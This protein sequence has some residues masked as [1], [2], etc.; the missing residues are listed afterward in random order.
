MEYCFVVGLPY[1][2]QEP[3]RSTRV[4]A[5]GPSVA[6]YTLPPEQNE[7]VRNFTSIGLTM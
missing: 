4:M 3:Y 7:V 6:L 5:Y 2:C 1:E